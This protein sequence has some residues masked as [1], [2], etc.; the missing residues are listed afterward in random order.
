MKMDTSEVNRGL[1]GMKSKISTAF[2]TIRKVGMAAFGAI[3]AAGGALAALTVNAV[4]FSTGI[5]TM[6]TQT[7]LT[8][9]EVLALQNAFKMVGVDTEQASTLVTE[10]KKRLAEARMGTGE[11]VIGLEALDMTVQ[12]LASMNTLEAFTAVMDGV[13][14]V[15]VESDKA[16]L[17]LDKF[18]GGAGMENLSVLSSRFGELME[19]ANENTE[20]LAG[21][22]ADGAGFDEMNMALA[23]V[24][25][26]LRELQILFVNALPLDRIK[27]MMNEA[28]L[29]S[30]GDKLT[31]GIEKFFKQPEATIAEWAVKAGTLLGEGII[32]GIIGFFLSGEGLLT[33]GK[34]IAL[35]LTMPFKVGGSLLQGAA[36]AENNKSEEEKRKGGIRINAPLIEKVLEGFKDITSS[37]AEGFGLTSTADV[38]EELVRQGNEANTLLR[39]I[40]S[41][42]PT[43]A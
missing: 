26:M 27:K 10:F 4:K 16:K 19:K 29:E 30:F 1:R 39:R 22:M 24:S 35:P 15:G 32:K 11:A 12:D 6:A 2:G 7:G 21:H 23:R 31:G 40:E 28:D 3:A 9:H 42:A 13:R 37:I 33:L 8:V 36:D 5:H 18:F 25:V 38:G 20:S 17:I 14:G 41:S 34:T 43:Y